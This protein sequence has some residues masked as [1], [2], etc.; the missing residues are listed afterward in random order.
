MGANQGILERKVMLVVYLQSLGAVEL[1][2]PGCR[3]VLVSE[4][5]LYSYLIHR[6]LIKIIILPILYCVYFMGIG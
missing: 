3:G 1:R 4:A 6:L 5:G 2:V